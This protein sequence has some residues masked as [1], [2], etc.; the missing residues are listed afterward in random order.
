MADSTLTR[1]GESAPKTAGGDTRTLGPSDSSDS[2]SDVAGGMSAQELDNDSDATGTG[3][4]GL[5]GASD[6]PRE[7]AD[8]APDAIL[9]DEDLVAD[10]DEDDLLP[11]DDA[12]ADDPAY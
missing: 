2:G 7:G 1:T 12:A 10:G 5:A 11:D 8:I 4:R 3:E 6:D 9:D